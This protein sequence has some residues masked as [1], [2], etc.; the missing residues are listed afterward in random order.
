M[1]PRS[2][3]ETKQMSPNVTRNDVTDLASGVDGDDDSVWR[4]LRFSS[5]NPNKEKQ[6]G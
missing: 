6:Y 4:F 1:P 3:L 2:L 5:R